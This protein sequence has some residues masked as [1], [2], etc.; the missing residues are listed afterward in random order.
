M[1]MLLFLMFNTLLYLVHGVM[2]LD[3]IIVD[4][5]SHHI[6]LRITSNYCDNL[7]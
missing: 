5:E 1:I 3:L 6:L 2:Y 7:S 4:I